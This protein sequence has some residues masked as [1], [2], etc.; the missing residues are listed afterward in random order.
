MTTVIAC[1]LILCIL[2]IS[3]AWIAAYHKKNQLGA[4]DNKEPRTQ[5]LALTGAGS[6]AVA[7]QSNSWEAL[8]V[9]GAAVFAVFISGIALE[10]IANLAMIFTL[11]RVVYIPMYVTDMDK[12]RS[13][14]FLGGFG[15]CIYLFSLAIRAS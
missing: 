4:V 3:C 9:F 14:I 8:A 6:R 13:L 7:A 5:A 12:F 2:P 15:I 1:L 10:E 11:L